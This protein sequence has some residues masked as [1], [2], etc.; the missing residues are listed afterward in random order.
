M[1][2]VNLPHLPQY[3]SVRSADKYDVPTKL[4]DVAYFELVRSM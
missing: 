3:R 1:I 4:E 2:R